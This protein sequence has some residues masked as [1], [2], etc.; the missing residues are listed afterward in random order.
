L[1]IP[2]RPV[3]ISQVIL[4]VLNNAFDAVE[5]SSQKWITINVVRSENHVEIQISD[6]GAGIAEQYREKIF[7]PFFTL[8]E[9]GKGTGL[10]LSISRS[11]IESQGGRIEL[12]LTKKH[13][14]FVIYLPLALRSLSPD[15]APPT[16]THAWAGSSITICAPEP[17]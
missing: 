8:K 5:S 3:Q 16:P 15:Q 10:G 14:T 9:V 7:Q 2:C 17:S 4:N 1:A 6:N 11:I 12:D 13:T